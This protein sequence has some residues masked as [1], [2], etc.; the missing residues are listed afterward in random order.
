MQVTFV[1]DFMNKTDFCWQWFKRVKRYTMA[2]EYN[3]ETDLPPLV[4]IGKRKREY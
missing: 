3:T 1:G 4:K 2:E